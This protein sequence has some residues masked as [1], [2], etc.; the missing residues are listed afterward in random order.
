MREIISLKHGVNVSKEHVRKTPVD[1]CETYGSFNVFHI[2]ENSKLKMFGFASQGCINGVSRR[3]IYFFVSATNNDS[4]V[5]AN[6]YRKAIGN[7]SR[8]PNAL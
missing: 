5:D 7:L 3:L 1:S 2:N 6:F 8:A 4:L